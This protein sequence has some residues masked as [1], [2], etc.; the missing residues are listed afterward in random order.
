[1]ELK[2]QEIQELCNQDRRKDPFK[3]EE[4]L[5]FQFLVDENYRSKFY[6]DQTSQKPSIEKFRSG[7]E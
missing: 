7:M 1:M 5:G 4:K 2:L 3:D 6:V